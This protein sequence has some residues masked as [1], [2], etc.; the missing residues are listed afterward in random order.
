MFSFISLLGDYFYEILGYNFHF[1][2]FW[3]VIRLVK[4]SKPGGQDAKIN[5]LF[6]AKLSFGF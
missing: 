3:S 5:Q 4:D 6:P 1:S 2:S